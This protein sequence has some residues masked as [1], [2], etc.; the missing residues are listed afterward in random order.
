MRD[1]LFLSVDDYAN[2]GA[3]LAIAG[4]TVG[5]DCVS[6][7]EFHHVFEYSDK[8]LLLKDVIG[9]L[10]PVEELQ[11]FADD[12]KVIVMMHAHP[13]HYPEGWLCGKRWSQKGIYK[14]S[15]QKWVVFH[16]VRPIA[17]GKA[18]IFNKVVDIT[19][20]QTADMF[21]NG[22]INEQ[23]LIPSVDTECIKPVFSDPEMIKKNKITFRHNPRHEGCK[24]SVIVNEVMKTFKDKCNYEFS[25][26]IKPWPENIKRMEQCDVYIVSMGEGEWGITALETASL[27]KVVVA[28][29][30]GLSKYEKEYCVC[31]IIVVEATGGNTN[32]PSDLNDA[33]EKILSFSPERIIELQ[34]QTREW[35]ERFHGYK[36]TGLRLKKL[37]ID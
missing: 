1:I 11:K 4:R 19:I 30:G 36:P 35:V 10:F 13:F 21:G 29:F 9:S 24:G 12:F 7:A 26:E 6:I 28:Q 27:G 14:R 5:M 15:W 37:L 34:K 22:G 31:P 33:I 16:T 20:N 23:W 25:S 32:N 17:P 2:I 3:S 18:N 8:S